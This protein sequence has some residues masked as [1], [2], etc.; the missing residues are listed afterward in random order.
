MCRGE[1][2]GLSSDLTLKIIGKQLFWPVKNSGEILDKIK[3]KCFLA[4]SVST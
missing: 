3:Q 4:S 2:R 1:Q